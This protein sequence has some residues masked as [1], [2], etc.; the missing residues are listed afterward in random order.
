MFLSPSTTVNGVFLML[1]SVFSSNFC[2]VDIDLK[3]KKWYAVTSGNQVV[4]LVTDW[5]EVA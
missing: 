4:M 3:G 2:L 1:L 5:A